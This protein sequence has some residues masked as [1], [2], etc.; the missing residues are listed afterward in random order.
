MKTSF[1]TLAAAAAVLFTLGQTAEAETRSFAKPKI[2]GDRLDLCVNWAQGCGKPAA[3]KWC[4]TKGYQQSVGHVVDHNIGNAHRTRLIGTGAVCD[5]GFCD[6][7]KVVTCFKPTP[8]RTYWKPKWGGDRLDWCVNWAQGC[9]KAAADKFCQ[10]KGFSTAKAFVMDPN[11]G[12]AHRTRL[13]G[14]G[15]VCDQG[16]CDGFRKITCGS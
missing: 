3:D 2:G 11:I 8:V 7:F 1:V 12:N 5:Q 4:Q 6:G 10:T 9:G 16:F 13:I 15:A 14:T